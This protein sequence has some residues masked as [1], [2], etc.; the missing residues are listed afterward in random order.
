M[1]DDTPHDGVP[2]DGVPLESDDVPVEKEIEDD[3]VS[4]PPVD[5]VRLLND[6]LSGDSKRER[7]AASAFI[8]VIT[9]TLSA[10]GA[11][12]RSAVWDDVI[13]EVL[14]KLLRHGRSVIK[15]HAW[16]RRVTI[17]T[18]TDFVRRDATRY[19]YGPLLLQVPWIFPASHALVEETVVRKE[20][21]EELHQAIE[22]LPPSLRSLVRLVYP[23]GPENEIDTHAEVAQRLGVRPYDVRNRLRRALCL[24]SRELRRERNLRRFRTPADAEDLEE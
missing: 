23:E 13:Q 6:F 7:A 15:P 18:Y 21:M 10:H 22:R 17:S 1:D 12:Q 5:W 19:T 9:G 3:P 4:T 16:V 11:Y 8:G 2:L 24:L 20:E 14:L